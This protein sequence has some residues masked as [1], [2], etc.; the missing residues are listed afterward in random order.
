MLNTFD[1]ANLT[2][3]LS[4]T[5]R[6]EPEPSAFTLRS[7]GDAS[8]R[9]QFYERCLA[10][11]FETRVMLTRYRD[12]P[13]AAQMPD[14]W[15]DKIVHSSLVVGALTLAGADLLPKDYVPPRGFFLLL[16]IDDAR[17]RSGERVFAALAEHGTISMPIQQTFW[18]RRFGV[19]VDQFG[20]PWEINSGAGRWST[21]V[22][23]CSGR[24]ALHVKPA[25]PSRRSVFSQRRRC[26]S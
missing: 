12:T 7:T 23:T 21:S 15:R 25:R 22:Q 3:I 10:G 1:N 24:T 26:R 18:A 11:T 16:D 13:A 9:I 8:A 4:L 6:S 19:L 17:R 2:T 5:L 20:I 14:D